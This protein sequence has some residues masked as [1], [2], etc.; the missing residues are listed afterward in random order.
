[1]GIPRLHEKSQFDVAIVGGG[2]AGICA[3]I[4]L[5]DHNMKVVIVDRDTE[6]NFG[7]LAMQSLGGYQG[8]WSKTGCDRSHRQ[9]A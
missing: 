8:G 5:L 9:A 2:L 7:G 1:M 4:E 6:Q 3:A